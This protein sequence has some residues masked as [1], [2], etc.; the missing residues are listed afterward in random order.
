[1]PNSSRAGLSN[2][3]IARRI[4]VGR[5]TVAQRLGSAMAKLGVDSRAQVASVAAR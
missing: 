1:L 5:P 4:G 3:E 2:I